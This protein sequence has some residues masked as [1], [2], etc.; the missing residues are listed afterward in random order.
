MNYSNL[1]PSPRIV[2]LEEEKINFARLTPG[3][4]GSGVPVAVQERLGRMCEGNAG[5]IPVQIVG[6]EEQ[7][8]EGYELTIAAAGVSLKASGEAGFGYGLDRLEQLCVAGRLPLGVIRDEPAMGMRGFHVNFGGLRHMDCEQSLEVLEGMRRWNLNTVLIEYA[9]RFPYRQHARISSVDAL[10]REQ[11]G[12]LV[13]RS[14]ELGI[15]VIPLQQCLGHVE[16]VLRHDEYAH[17]REEEEKQDQWCPLNEGSF[18]LFCELVDDV[19]ETHP[20]LKM[21]HLGGDETRRLGECPRCAEFA[22]EKGKGGLYLEFVQRAIQHVVD[23]GLTPIVWDDM[24]CHYPEILDELPREL[25]IMYW[26]Y[27]T[28]QVE[29]AVFVARP[30]G[31]GVVV[32][33][34]WKEEWAGELDEVERRM[35][36]RFTAPIDFETDRFRDRFFGRISGSLRAV[37]GGGIPQASARF[38]ISGVLSG[39]RISRH[40]LRGGRQQ[41]FAVERVARFSPV[42]GQYRRLVAADGGV[43]LYGGGDQRLVRFSHRDADARDHVHRADRLES[44]GLRNRR[45]SVTDVLQ[46]SFDFHVLGKSRLCRT[47]VERRCYVI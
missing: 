38:S 37:S 41:L 5:K 17:L 13:S 8:A 32:D 43:G 18:D 27:W 45:E 40:R 2:E 25:V 24:I 28:T 30:E 31:C 33:R 12:A 7:P 44:G 11:V 26:E 36:D 19:I 47:V 20:G 29:S 23:R 15:Q 46:Y 39:S 16:H 34:R 14:R 3:S 4:A 10:K 42:H 6:D 35:I 9:E 21:V 22:R 1:L